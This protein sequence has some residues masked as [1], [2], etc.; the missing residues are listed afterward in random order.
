VTEFI[1]CVLEQFGKHRIFHRTLYRRP[2]SIGN[3]RATHRRKPCCAA[4]QLFYVHADD[5]SPFSAHN[6]F[7]LFGSFL[8]AE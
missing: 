3:R 7:L 1:G 8:D 6:V 2:A 5:F 4:S